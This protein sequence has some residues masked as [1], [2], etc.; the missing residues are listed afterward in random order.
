MIAQTCLPDRYVKGVSA[1][2]GIR[3]TN[4]IDVMT[5]VNNRDI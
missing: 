3:L 5:F 2:L 1:P 4:N